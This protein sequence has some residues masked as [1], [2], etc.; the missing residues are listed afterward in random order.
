MARRAA[1]FGDDAQAYDRERPSYPAELVDELRRGSP[2]LAHRVPPD[3]RR[4]ELAVGEVVDRRGGGGRRGS[5]RLDDRT[6]L[7]C[8]P[9]LR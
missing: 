6:T 2:L 4:A 7:S 5:L 8:W 3:E 1:S 9:R